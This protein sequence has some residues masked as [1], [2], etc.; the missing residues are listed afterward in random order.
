MLKKDLKMDALHFINSGIA[1]NCLV[2]IK[3][4]GLLDLM[5]KKRAITSAMLLDPQVCS[6]Y[7]AAYLECQLRSRRY[8]GRPAIGAD[9]CDRLSSL[10]LSGLALFGLK[11]PSLLQFD[12]SGIDF[13]K[14]IK[15]AVPPQL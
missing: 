6:N 2:L 15:A 8:S 14:M 12:E 11:F 13:P 4:L 3:E 10:L 5:L 1:C 9:L 7:T